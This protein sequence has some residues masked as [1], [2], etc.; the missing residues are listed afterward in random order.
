MNCVIQISSLSNGCWYLFRKNLHVFER[1]R[2]FVKKKPAFQTADVICLIKTVVVPTTEEV[3][4]LQSH[5]HVYPVNLDN[6]FCSL[7][8]TC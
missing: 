4:T 8:F 1:L 5:A 2:L 6:M 3:E 7:Q